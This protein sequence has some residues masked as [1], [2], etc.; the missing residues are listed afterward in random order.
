MTVTIGNVTSPVTRLLNVHGKLWCAIQGTVK[1]LNTTTLQ[2][3][4]EFK[5]SD[6][7]ITEM[8]VAKN[9]VWISLQNSAIIECYHCNE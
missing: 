8:V 5:I 9:C 3:E 4:N 6:R 1:I 2:I 7:L